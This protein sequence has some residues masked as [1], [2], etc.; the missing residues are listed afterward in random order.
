M[1]ISSTSDAMC[2]LK[3]WQNL[4]SLYDIYWIASLKMYH[5]NRQISYQ[6]GLMSN[7]IW[8]LTMSVN[9]ND[10]TIL[11]RR[12]HEED[13]RGS[14]C[15][16]CI[17]TKGVFGLLESTLWTWSYTD[18]KIYTGCGDKPS[19]TIWYFYSLKYYIHVGTVLKVLVTMP[20]LSPTFSISSSSGSPY[21]K[22][23]LI[24]LP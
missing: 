5:F 8:T 9:L 14:N 3:G 17:G 18:R 11:F 21:N 20:Q 16:Q 12:D 2:L 10:F 19:Q 1:L 15:W 22:H 7:K 4:S 6:I 24:W 23:M 13:V